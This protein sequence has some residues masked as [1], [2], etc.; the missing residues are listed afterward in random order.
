MK[1]VTESSRKTTQEC[2]ADI[3]LGMYLENC[4]SSINHND[5]YARQE[6]EI[7]IFRKK[8]IGLHL[9]VR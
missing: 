1:Y 8:K 7:V 3:S 2:E 6:I 9:V 5:E 4:I